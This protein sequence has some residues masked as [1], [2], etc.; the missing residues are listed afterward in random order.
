LPDR[1]IGNLRVQATTFAKRFCFGRR[2][3]NQIYNSR[4]PVPL[5]GRIAIVTDAGWD[6]VDAGR[7][8]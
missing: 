2:D 4:H 5:Q 7:R 1:Q 6:A 3:P 8:F